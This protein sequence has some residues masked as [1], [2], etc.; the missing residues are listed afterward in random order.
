M[1]QEE[2][3]FRTLRNKFWKRSNKIEEEIELKEQ[4]RK[5]I[6]NI[7]ELKK[8]IKGWEFKSVKILQ[9]LNYEKYDEIV[10]IGKIELKL[11]R[12]GI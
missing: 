11:K 1:L 6:D 8:E 9:D 5:K 7:K 2:L 10:E 4:A 12:S 3:W